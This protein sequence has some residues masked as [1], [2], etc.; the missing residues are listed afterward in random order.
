MLT[1]LTELAQTTA[2]M[3]GVYAALAIP[4]LLLAPAEE[5]AR[6][7]P[8]VAVAGRVRALVESGSVD[9]LLILLASVRAVTRD[10]VLN[11]AALFLLLCTTP[12]GAT[13]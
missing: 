10:A 13:S 5:W 2:L 3:T 6:P 1:S 9:P 7:R 11:A 8:V 12:K 4:V